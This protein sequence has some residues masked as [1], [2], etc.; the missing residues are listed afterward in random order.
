VGI[1]S[2]FLQPDK[3]SLSDAAIVRI[4]RGGGSVTPETG[5]QIA[6]VLACVRVLSESVAM[7]PLELRARDGRGTRRATENPLYTLLHDLP[8]PEMTSVEMRMALMGHLAAWGNAY[9][10]IVYDGAGRRRELWPLPPNR[11]EAVRARNGDLLYKYQEDDGQFTVFRAWEIMHIRGL[12]FDG[13]TGYSPIG[14]ARRTFESKARME[15]FEAAFWAN[16][17]QPG[18]ILKHPGKLSDKAYQRLMESWEARHGGAG[19][20]NRMA[21]LEE[22]L[23]VEAMG[24]P[25]SDAQFLETQKYNRTEIAAL[26]RVPSHMINDLERATFSNIEQM[27]MEFVSYSLMPWLVMWEQAIARDLLSPQERKRFYAKHKVQALL[28][29]DNQ[30]RS[31][32]YTSALQYGWMSINDVR[33]LEDLN[34][35]DNG[36][37]YFVPMNMTTLEAAVEGPADPPAPVPAQLQDDTPDDNPD[38][39]PDDNADDQVRALAPLVL[40]VERRLRARIGNDVRLQGAKAMRKGGRSELS[41]WGEGQ[42]HDWRMA[43]ES[44][45]APVLDAAG[46]LG[47]VL[48]ADVGEWVTRAYQ[49]AIRDL[50]SGEQTNE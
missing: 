1:L 47:V 33:E 31:E 23:A 46:A 10:Q 3:R 40:D 30:S 36:D 7:L 49:A 25:Q 42:I 44:M 24:I 17:A 9:A 41:E 8:N 35:I 4:L 50:I 14:M 6:S 43:G 20:A 38:D 48:A 45:L 11:M 28:R 15:E 16:G 21:I 2:S 37:V 27:S 18:T 29:G 22:G 34:P 13:L 5:L 26:F 39:T 12:S 32:F 19:N